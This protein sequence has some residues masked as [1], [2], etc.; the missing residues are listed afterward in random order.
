MNFH[1]I[2]CLPGCWDSP[3]WLQH[4]GRLPFATNPHRFSVRILEKQFILISGE[5]H[6]LLSI[7]SVCQLVKWLNLFCQSASLSE[8]SSQILARGWKNPAATTGR[9][10]WNWMGGMSLAM[11]AKWKI[12][13]GLKH[14]LDVWNIYW[15]SSIIPID[16]LIFFQRGWH[17]DTTHQ[18]P[19]S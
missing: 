4:A 10:D 17:V 18:L 15:V 19:F 3:T 14:F 2:H 1:P 16:E 11:V 6:R 5:F 12:P 8:Q 13:G 9:H 7:E